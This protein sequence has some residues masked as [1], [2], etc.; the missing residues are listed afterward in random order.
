MNRVVAYFTVL[1]KHLHEWNE[2]NNE[3]SRHI[4]VHSVLEPRFQYGIANHYTVMFVQ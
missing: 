1:P 3:K 4:R 2:E